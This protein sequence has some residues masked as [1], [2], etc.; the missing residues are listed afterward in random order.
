MKLTLAKINL[1]VA[2]M[3][4]YGQACAIARALDIVGDRW[5]LLL[6]RELT[7][8]PRRYR[9]P[10][11]RPAGHPQQRPG[12]TP[13]G[14]AGR[15]RHHPAHPPGTHRRDRVR[16]DRRRPGA[17]ARTHR[18]AALGPALRT[19]TV[20]GRRGPARLGTAWRRGPAG[21]PAR[22]ADLRAPGRPEGLLPRLRRRHA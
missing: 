12:R 1:T 2:S 8:G 16:A 10:R 9:R 7:L 3:K 18:T 20:P 21:R 22:R 17:A 14:P 19:R 4:H 13:E 15:R 6:V 5:S 11:H